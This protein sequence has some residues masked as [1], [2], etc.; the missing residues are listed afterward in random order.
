MQLIAKNIKITAL[1]DEQHWGTSF[2][3]N[4][5]FILLE[6]EG[7]IEEAGQKKGKE[8]L[9][10]LL[11]KITNYKDRN[12]VTASELIDWAREIKFIQTLTI[13]FLQSDILYLANLGSGEVILRRKDK[14]GKILSSNETSSG[15]VDVG[16]VIL[17]CS[18]TFLNCLDKKILEEILQNQNITEMGEETYSNLVSNPTSAGAT[19]LFLDVENQI[20]TPDAEISY[21]EVE[22]KDFKTIIRK[23]WQNIVT[24][25]KRKK[26]N[27]FEDGEEAK[28]KKTLLTIAIILIL[29]LILSIFLNINHSQITVKQNHLKQTLELVSHQYDE[30]VSLIDL[31]PG[32][33]RLLLSDSKLSLSQVFPEFQKNSAEYK[34]INE[35][36]N[37]IA[38]KEVDAYKIFKFT[39]VPLF[40]D[41]NLIKNGGIAQKIAIHQKTAAILDIKNKL[42]YSLGLDKKQA[43]IVAGSEVVKDAQTI[44]VHGKQIYILNGDGISEIDISSKSTKTIIKSDKEWGEIGEMVAFGGNLYLLDRK[45]N[46]IWKYIAQDVGFSS[47][48]SY[49]NPDVRISLA[50]SGKMIIDGS[51]WILADPG[52]ILK[53]TNGH[54]ESFTFKGLSDNISDIATFYTSDEDKNLYILDKHSQRILTFDKDGNYLSQYQWEELKNA[55][56]IVVSE[57]EKKIFVIVKGSI[58]AIDLKQ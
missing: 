50:N 18:K 56:N 26:D 2:S 54:G 34:Q 31:N 17:F 19:A 43:A 53:F 41:I 15:K 9:D 30:A 48:A 29:L 44:A 5:L 20:V 12:L 55:D 52:T 22:T 38:E 14:I 8:I 58:Y 42:V 16:D 51:V 6:V 28:P 32:R 11:T 39:T 10:I 4:G 21:P 36:L 7:N 27:F 24:I 47:R 25:I 13:G 49:L 33:A 23:N 37:K 35:W 40:Y 46:S 1:S 3:E 57:E 45:N